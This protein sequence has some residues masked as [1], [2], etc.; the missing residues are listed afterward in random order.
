MAE[1]TLELATDQRGF[2]SGERI[3]GTFGWS[4][5]KSCTALE[6]RL[7][8]YTQGKGTQD[9]GIVQTRR[10]GNPVMAGQE[11]FEMELPEGPYSFSG[12]LITLAWALE[13]V[14]LPG[15]EAERVDLVLS[16]TGQEVRLDGPLPAVR[17]V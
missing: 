6:L 17:R 7:F 13:L 14:A 2:R 10:V 12:R 4:L 11:L 8:W 5:E 15:D 16:P 1:L 3:R 9:V